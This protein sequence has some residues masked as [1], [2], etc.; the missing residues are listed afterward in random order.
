MVCQGVRP[1]LGS[2]FANVTPNTLRLD[3]NQDEEYNKDEI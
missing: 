3:F 1:C 2:P